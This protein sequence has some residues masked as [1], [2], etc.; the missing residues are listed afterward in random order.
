MEKKK[1]FYGWDEET[2]HRIEREYEQ[3]WLNNRHLYY[4]EERLQMIMQKEQS[5]KD[6][7]T[8]H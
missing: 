8:I 7:G 3:K 6:K 2:F 4:S 5:E 1:R